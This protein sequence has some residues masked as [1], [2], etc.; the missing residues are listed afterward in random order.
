MRRTSSSPPEAMAWA[1]LSTT[2]RSACSSRSASTRQSTG[3]AGDWLSTVTSRVWKSAEASIS[4]LETTAAQI[5]ILQ[6]KLDRAGEI[7]EG[8]DDAI[9]AADLALDDVEVAQRVAADLNLVPEQFQVNDD[10]VD[11]V[12]DFV[13]DAG[14]E[15]ADRGHAARNLQLGFDLPNGFEVVDGEQSAEGMTVA[16]LGVVD[17]VEG[18]LDA[19]A[20]FGGDFFLDD[21][22]AALE[23]VA[24]EAA[25]AGVAVEDLAD[26]SAEDAFAADVEEALAGAGDQDG[27]GVAG[28]EHDAVLQVGE[29]LVEVLAQG[30][31]DLLDV[32]DALAEALDL[33]GNLSD[34]VVA[35]RRDSRSGTGSWGRHQL[36]FDAAQFAGCGGSASASCAASSVKAL[37]DLLDGLQSEVGHEGGDDHG[38]DHGQAHETER[39]DQPGLE[40]VAEKGGANADADGQEG[41]IVAVEAERDVVDLGPARRRCGRCG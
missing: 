16:G 40:G 27:A 36:G 21:G 32:A 30:G 31:E 18:D 35:A 14:R 23:R 4:T 33:A 7:D 10:G 2:L 20:G 39:L 24:Y 3:R 19:A 15:S 37:A 9:E 1:P 38:D 6:L 28:E 17:E 8:L 41:L 26:F 25:E 11:G 29:D 34:S 5:L 13:A 12:L 22:H